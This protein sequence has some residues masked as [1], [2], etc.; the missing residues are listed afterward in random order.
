MGN[1]RYLGLKLKDISQDGSV[2]S[3]NIEMFLQQV[4]EMYLLYCRLNGS[5]VTQVRFAYPLAF[6]QQKRQ[7]FQTRVSE[8]VKSTAQRAGMENC[9]A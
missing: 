4:L 9:T 3:C 7:A 2:A 1:Q 8:L 5:R 6:D